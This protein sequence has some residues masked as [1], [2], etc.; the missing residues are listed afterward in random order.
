MNWRI[1]LL[2]GQVTIEIS[3]DT[4]VE[5]VKRKST[6]GSRF[7]FGTVDKTEA[8]VFYAYR[9]ELFD[10]LGYW[11]GSTNEVII[12]NRVS[13]A[14]KVT[15]DFKPP[16]SIL[17]AYGLISLFLLIFGSFLIQENGFFVS[18]IIL[19][20]LYVGLVLR[21]NSQFHYLVTDLEQ[22]EENYKMGIR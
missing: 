16:N 22:M 14:T 17:I 18:F 13:D 20:T 3:F 2:R 15:V 9:E 21:Q 10:R 11:S 5:Y 19:L 4:L 1:F 8:R 6:R 12:T 7:K